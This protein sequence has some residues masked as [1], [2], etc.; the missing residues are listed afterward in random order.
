MKQHIL[1]AKYWSTYS[2]GL[3]SVFFVSF[4]I[5]KNAKI[6]EKLT[7]LPTEFEVRSGAASS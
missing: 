1:T 2:S 3:S 6:V 4:K 7:R 5:A